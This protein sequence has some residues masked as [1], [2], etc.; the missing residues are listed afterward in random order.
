MSPED[1]E[2]PTMVSAEAKGQKNYT[3][4]TPNMTYMQ[5]PTPSC[6]CCTIFAFFEFYVVLLLNFLKL[7]SE[8]QNYYI[9]IMRQKLECFL[10]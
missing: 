3:Q 8:F 10:A 1:I 2:V 9:T 4:N 6:I 7:F 5:K